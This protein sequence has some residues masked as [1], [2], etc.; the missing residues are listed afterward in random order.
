MTQSSLANITYISTN[1]KVCYVNFFPPCALC[2]SAANDDKRS[3]EDN[4]KTSE[5]HS[6][7]SLNLCASYDSESDDEPEPPPKKHNL[8]S[9]DEPE[10]PPKKKR[11]KKR[12]NGW[13]HIKT[14]K[15]IKNYYRKNPFYIAKPQTR[16][17][18]RSEN[19]AL[20]VF[21]FIV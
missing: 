20:D 4:R 12:G 2:S 1:A 9:N 7:N 18:K 13:T 8:E 6:S 19:M 15:K 16:T 3:V 5:M 14:K 10:P 21:L 17:S 11:R